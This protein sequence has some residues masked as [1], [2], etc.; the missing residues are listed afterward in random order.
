MASTPKEAP[1]N[2]SKKEIQ[3]A[4]NSIWRHTN[5]PADPQ[6]QRQG[7]ET[8]LKLLNQLL[9]EEENR[10]ISILKVGVV[11]NVLKACRHLDSSTLS[12]ELLEEALG[13]LEKNA[14]LWNVNMLSYLFVPLAK[15]NK[16][17]QH[18]QALL[19]RVLTT[20][21][22]AKLD[23]RA[24]HQIMGG[25]AKEKRGN[26][27]PHAEQLL[28]RLEQLHEQ[29]QLKESPD[30]VLYT[31]VLGMLA[32][33]TSDPS[34]INKAETLFRRMELSKEPSL[35]PTLI[36]CTTMLRCFA[37]RGMVKEA[38][39][40][41]YRMYELH[42]SGQLDENPD[43]V[44]LRCV[45][46]AQRRSNALNR[47]E[48]NNT[49]VTAHRPSAPNSIQTIRD[50]TS[51][52]LKAPIGSLNGTMLQNATDVI[53]FHIYK[54]PDKSQGAKTALLILI[55][56]LQEERETPST[57]VLQRG[58][59]FN[60][61]RAC[62]RSSACI[63]VDDL[64]TAL[65]LLEQ[66]K[67]QLL[68]TKIFT[69]VL[70]AIAKCSKDV[71]APDRA[72]AIL[73]RPKQRIKPN[74]YHY[75][76]VLGGYA[77]RGGAKKAEQL[78]KQMQKLQKAKTLAGGPN[79]ITYNIVLDALS[80]SREVDAVERA[81]AIL[82]KMN[83][84]TR[85]E[86]DMFTYTSLFNLYAHHSEGDKAV[87]LLEQVIGLQTNGKLKDGLHEVAYRCV[88]DAL[89]KS[90]EEPERAEK[91]LVQMRERKVQPNLY[92]YCGVLS[93]FA[94]TGKA[95]ECERLLQEMQEFHAAG[96]LH[97]APNVVA[98]NSVV[99]GWAK[100]GEV[101][102]PF[103]ARDAMDNMIKAGIQPN[104]I[105]YNCFL[106]ACGGKGKDAELILKQMHELHAKG[107][108]EAAPNTISYNYALDALGRSGDREWTV[109]RAESL[110]SKMIEL[111][112]SGVAD[113]K[114][115]MISYRSLLRCYANWKMV[116]DA[117]QLLHRMQKMHK[118]GK[119]EYGPDRISYS[120][121]IDALNK[122]DE[123]DGAKKRAGA[124]QKQLEEIYGEE[125]ANAPW[126]GQVDQVDAL[127][128]YMGGFGTGV[129]TSI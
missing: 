20:S 17:F 90:G 41:L 120:I 96:N 36:A 19:D 30:V 28:Q 55:R 32:K 121:V 67:G 114:P 13:L 102:A 51:V 44:A 107:E 6:L 53:W 127:L 26:L 126:M 124:L 70:G 57:R 40:L 104:V 94:R 74:C 78:L 12:A 27:F 76:A 33:Q 47:S 21:T 37:N 72:E 112:E 7:A 5:T 29:G 119:L 2:L 39:E 85:I 68:D 24:C 82:K 60:V 118:K 42:A 43:A 45:K 66:H 49:T 92:H 73:Q 22:L 103:R 58:M 99:F 75:N 59:V 79:T 64:E 110:V 18:P 69:Q 123:D 77:K 15:T 38:Q 101:D 93:A 3:N 106:A 115:N 61:L 81:E 105:T 86:P 97:D 52:V 87:Q 25:L 117:E 62:S 125:Q 100:S 113:T 9:E 108:L 16:Y 23:P 14:R 1:A 65:H 128:E 46:D 34:S 109:L 71:D 4:L 31:M 95:Q 83:K 54:N 11:F 10:A 84:D 91:V 116:S 129:P 80:K 50:T 56:L 63:S 35:R 89:A 88:I 122:S 111:H 8:S 98:F 48:I